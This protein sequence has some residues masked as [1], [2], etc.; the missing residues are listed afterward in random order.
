M[1]HI[2]LFKL[3][4]PPLYKHECMPPG[5]PYSKGKSLSKMLGHPPLHSL[6]AGGR[7]LGLSQP[8]C[9]KDCYPDKIFSHLG[10]LNKS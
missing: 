7:G 10:L 1:N 8:N 3:H 2:E 6:Q 4:W 5:Q 9:K